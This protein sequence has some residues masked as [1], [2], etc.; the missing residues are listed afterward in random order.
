MTFYIDV[1][2]LTVLVIGNFT[3]VIG[4]VL[5]SLKSHPGEQ[6]GVRAEPQSCS[7]YLIMYWHLFHFVKVVSEIPLRLILFR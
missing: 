3:K 2:E 1:K 5:A 7:S 4:A 6:V